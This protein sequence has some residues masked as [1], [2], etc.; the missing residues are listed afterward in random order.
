LGELGSWLKM[1]KVVN[2]GMIRDVITSE[3]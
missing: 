3:N 1:I 2:H